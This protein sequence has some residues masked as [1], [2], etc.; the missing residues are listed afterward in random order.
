MKKNN[1]N[2]NKIYTDEYWDAL[3]DLSYNFDGFDDL[4]GGFLGYE[5]AFGIDKKEYDDYIRI[6]RIEYKTRMSYDEFL[7]LDVLEQM[8]LC[9]LLDLHTPSE[10]KQKRLNKKIDSISN[11][12]KL[13]RKLEKDIKIYD[14][15]EKVKKL[16][17]KK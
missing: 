10:K 1:S 16:V 13:D 3:C 15:K 6:K 17:F 14:F 8:K 9:E 11:P 7:Q 5:G 12:S 2:D 4:Y